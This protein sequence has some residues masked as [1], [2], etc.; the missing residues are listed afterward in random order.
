VSS[1]FHFA[2]GSACERRRLNA[3]VRSICTGAIFLGNL[4]VF[5][6]RF[7][8]THWEA[9]TTLVKYIQLGAA[10]TGSKAGTVLPAR[11]VDSGLPEAGVHIISSGGISCG[12]DASL[13]VVKLRA[14]ENEAFQTSQLLDYAWR[15][16]EGVVFGQTFGYTF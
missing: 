8:T 10:R 15:Q 14:G 5:D 2:T 1:S 3:L 4:G 13:H 9:Y 11:F 16:T 6:G 12:I 7:C